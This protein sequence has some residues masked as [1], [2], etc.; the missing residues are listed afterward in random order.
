MKKLIFILLTLMVCAISIF[1]QSQAEQDRGMN[2]QAVAFDATGKAM[3]KLPINIKISFSSK[4][5][6]LIT[7]YTE[8]HQASTN[9]LGV[10]NLIIGEGLNRVGQIST[11][12]WGKEQIWLDVEVNSLGKRALNMKQSTLI[13]AVPYAFHAARADQIIENDQSLEKAQSIYWLTSGND[14]T[15]P[16]T[17]FVGTSD[18]KNLVIKTNGIINAIVTKEG[19]VQI[20]GRTSGFDS[21]VNNY[22]L[23]VRG[24]DNGVSK[25]GVYIK[26]TGSRNNSNNFVT[27]GDDERFKWGEI[28]GQT[29]EE[30]KNTWDYKLQDELYD[31]TRTL[32]RSS[33]KNL[34]N[35]AKSLFS[36]GARASASLFFSFAAPGFFAAAAASTSLATTIATEAMSVLRQSQ[37]WANESAKHIGVEYASGGGDYAEWLKRNPAER[38][39]QFG[40]IVGIKA[41]LVSLNTHDADHIMVIST[42]PIVLGNSPQPN[43]EK[44]YEKVAF[45]GQAPVRVM[46]EVAVGDYILAS[47]NNDGMGIAVNPAKMTAADFS[48]VVGVAW[49]SGK[50]LVINIIIIGI[51]LNKNDLAPKVEEASQK[52]DNIIAYLQGNGALHPEGA[53]VALTTSSVTTYKATAETHQDAAKNAQF[54]QYVD[55][56]SDFFKDFYSKLAAQMQA[57]GMDLFQAPE[58]RALFNDP[59]NSLKKMW[60]DPAFK[61]HWQLID[62]KLKYSH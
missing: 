60:R 62:E 24:L 2:F 28:Q 7:Y 51:G 43:Q 45:L 19:Q 42:R 49:E 55:S 10:F 31:I 8:T 39:H 35:E 16:P 37:T 13:R 53:A 11:I 21:D 17:H 15:V 38:E 59:I 36:A 48:K 47:G 40:E 26:V 29:E 52:I 32:L 3:A 57:Q 1:G 56:Q 33:E 50:N 46:G 18:N 34:L 44:H 23:L 54:D 22:P 30:L 5:D 14:G 58:M 27:F 12:P 20:Y 6:N 25:Q 41:G 4:H 9:E 61:A